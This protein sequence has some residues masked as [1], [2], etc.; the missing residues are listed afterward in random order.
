MCKKVTKEVTLGIL[1]SIVEGTAEFTDFGP[2]SELQIMNLPGFEADFN[3]KE[4]YRKIFLNNMKARLT[5]SEE[6]FLGEGSEVIYD[7]VEKFTANF[8]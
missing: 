3:D 7:L 4:S 2:F 6:N 5:F 8:S 1:E